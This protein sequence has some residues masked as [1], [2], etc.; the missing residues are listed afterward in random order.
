MGFQMADQAYTTDRRGNKLARLFIL[1][2]GLI[3]MT[4]ALC[5]I[6]SAFG[7]DRILTTAD[8]LFGIS[9][10]NLM[11]S[12]GLLEVCIASLCLLVNQDRLN[13]ILIIWL[14]TAFAIYRIGLW[15]VGWKIPC[16]CLGTMTTAIHVSPVIA[17]HVMEAVLLYLLVGSTLLLIKPRFKPV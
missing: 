14:A 2:S 13:L 3:L 7:H 17:D 10:G 15:W 12:V 9:F 8:P 11:L 1:S 5:K 6:I 16:H 4:T